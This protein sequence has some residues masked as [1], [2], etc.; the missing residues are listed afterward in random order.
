MRVPTLVTYAMLALCPSGCLSDAPE[1]G[2]AGYSFDSLVTSFANDFAALK[3]PA[4]ELSFRDNLDQLGSRQALQ[5][6][7]SVFGRYADRLAGVDRS[8]LDACERIELSVIEAETRMG[9][10]RAALGLRQ[11]AAATPPTD[12]RSLSELELGRDWYVYFLER[13]NGAPLDPDWLYA[14]GEREL[15]NA[16]A[17]FDELRRRMGFADTASLFSHLQNNAERLDGDEPTKALFETR[18][19]QVRGRLSEIFAG[20]YGVSPAAI[21]RSDR[22]SSF[23]VPGYYQLAEAT[24][25]YNVLDGDTYEARQADWLFLH[26]ATPGHHFQVTA[27]RDSNRCKSRLPEI[28]HPAYVEGWAAYVE[29]LGEDLGLYREPEARLA[30]I[31]W[32][33]VR[34][35]RVALDVALNYYGWS[36]EQALAYW[37]ERVRGQHDIAEREIARMRRW[38]AQ[39]VTYKY[40]ASVFE[41]VR[42]R[43]TQHGIDI[44]AFHDAALAYGSMPLASFEALFPILVAS[45]PG[46]IATDTVN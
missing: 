29:T 42:Q 1:I 22:G 41:R 39:V 4:L 34:S 30:A 9:L 37:H 45:R 18:Q 5:R 17:A 36:D 15:D 3:L 16:V 26:E 2:A 27:A 19:A 21:A 14:F 40:G 23:P 25:Y 46:S 6:Q 43:Y 35:V 44:V 7:Q 11:L 38:P 12:V 10:R 33:M 24:F 28:F 13:W 8:V 32:D 20:D 31:E